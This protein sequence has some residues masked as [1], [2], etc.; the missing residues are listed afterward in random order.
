[1]SKSIV[2]RAVTFLQKRHPKALALQ[3]AATLTSA[4]G[5]SFEFWRVIVQDPQAGLKLRAIVVPSSIP[6][7]AM[8]V[9]IA[10][11]H[12][13]FG[14]LDALTEVRSS[15]IYRPYE[16]EISSIDMPL[17]PRLVF[18]SDAVR[19]NQEAIS[20]ACRTLGLFVEFIAENEMYDTLFISY[21]GPD[22]KAAAR[23]NGYLASHGVKTWFFPKDSVPGEKLHRTMSEGV[24][25]HARVMLLCSQHSLV[26]PG[27]LNEI[28][29][30][31]ERE[32]R[33]G[34]GTI[35]IPVALDDFVYQDWAPQRRD[36][37]V[38]IRDR[39]IPKLARDEAGEIEVSSLDRVLTALNRR[40]G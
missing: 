24:N 22:E 37:A 30:A 25:S 8:P 31:L 28:E 19:V 29:R 16:P 11:L 40:I 5:P 9:I 12:G 27:V 21:G 35:L 2:T 26:R 7:D 33:E 23:I 4:G 34:G 3:E 15:N 36:L 20:Q 38:Q 10:N 17:S 18:Y 14:K 13:D 32:A 6:D 1:M 39:V